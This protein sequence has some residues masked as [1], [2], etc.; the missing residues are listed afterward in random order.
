M[1]QRE[2][3]LVHH[4]PVDELH[5]PVPVGVRVSPLR[6]NGRVERHP[7]ALVRK[8]RLEIHGRQKI[9]ALPYIAA[10]TDNSV[11]EME[12]PVLIQRLLPIVERTDE[13][14]PLYG[15]KRALVDSLIS[16]DFPIQGCARF[17][18]AADDLVRFQKI[19]FRSAGDKKFLPTTHTLSP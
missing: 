11:D 2:I 14:F 6:E 10:R 13:L 16:A 9:H 5:R 12:I 7:H 8:V 15:Q 19:R 4:R 17:V 18:P 1:Q 3:A